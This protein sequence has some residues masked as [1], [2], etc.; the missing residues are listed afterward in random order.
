[1]YIYILYIIYRYTYWVYIYMHTYSHRYSC[2]LVIS[3]Y[4]KSF[5]QYFDKLLNYKNLEKF[6]AIKRKNILSKLHLQ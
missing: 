4:H 3:S 2:R 1:M 6:I 5:Q